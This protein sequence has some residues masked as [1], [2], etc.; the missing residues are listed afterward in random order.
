MQKVEQ[1]QFSQKLTHDKSSVA[2]DFQK[3]EEVY[4]RNFS[5][6]GS[7]WLA[8]HIT[9][10]TGPVSVEV[11][12]EDGSM[13]RRHFDQIHKKLASTSENS[14][15]HSEEW[16]D[17]SAFLSYPPTPHS[18]TVTET[19]S[20]EPQPTDSDTTSSGTAEISVFN[21]STVPNSASVPIRRNPPRNRKLPEKLTY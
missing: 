21:P 11:Q 10:L 16:E 15:P 7:C 19:T 9:K 20:T 17:A 14:T 4:A 3:G 18:E 1:K 5:T 13:I 2:R 8:D 6:Q 12:L